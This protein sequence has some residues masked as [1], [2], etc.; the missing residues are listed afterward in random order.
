MR[1]FQHLETVSVWLHRARHLIFEE[2]AAPIGGETSFLFKPLNRWRD[3]L[4]LWLF[5]L[6]WQSVLCSLWQ[7]IRYGNAFHF[8]S[9]G[10]DIE[11][12]IRVP[13]FSPFLMNYSSPLN[14]LWFPPVIAPQDL[15]F[16]HTWL[17]C[18]RDTFQWEV[19][20]CASFPYVHCE[21]SR[22]VMEDATVLK[23]LRLNCWFCCTPL[24]ICLYSLTLLS[25]LSFAVSLTA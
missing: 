25:L 7:A 11:T 5:L 9:T 1:F 8:W 20:C 13:G 4:L 16:L 18:R 23:V 3:G 24:N 22:T 14:G 2:C 6:L 15:F 12:F 21:K 10:L 17:E 19:Y